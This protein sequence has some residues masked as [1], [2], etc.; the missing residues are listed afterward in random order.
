MKIFTARV[1]AKKMDKTA[2]VMVERMFSHPVYKKRIKKVKKYHVH[3]ELGAKV[4]EDVKFVAS[5]PFSKLKKWKVIE[6][7]GRKNKDD[8]DK[9]GKK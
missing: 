6:I 8:K 1:V 4:G 2:T 5:K 9:K 7:I 3:D